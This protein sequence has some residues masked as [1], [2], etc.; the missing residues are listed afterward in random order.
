[1]RDCPSSHYRIAPK[2]VAFRARTACAKTF[3]AV[4]ETKNALW[5]QLSKPN[6]TRGRVGQKWYRSSRMGSA[7]V[8]FYR[9]WDRDCK[10]AA[11]ES[12]AADFEIAKTTSADKSARFQ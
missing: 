9:N 11:W 5:S 1:C 7:G 4:I 12:Q 3:S 2:G 10:S 6:W 8:R